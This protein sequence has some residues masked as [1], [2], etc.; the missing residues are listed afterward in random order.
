MATTGA[1]QR[2]QRELHD[3]DD[4]SCTTATATTG[5]ARRRRRELHNGNDGSSTTAATGAARRRR[6][7]STDDG[8]CLT[9]TASCLTTTASSILEQSCLCSKSSKVVFAQSCLCSKSSEVVFAQFSSEDNSKIEQR[10]L[11]SKIEQRVCLAH[12][13]P[14]LRCP[15]FIL[16]ADAYHHVLPLKNITC[17]KSIFARY[18]V[19]SSYKYRYSS[20]TY[21]SLLMLG[22]EHRQYHQ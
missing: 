13:I 9:A 8:S 14:C 11:C 3:G 5:A 19:T 1:A 16:L 2:R 20:S 4:G 6:L 7:I 12:T 10:Q 17:F 21:Y 18:R 22:R 15:L